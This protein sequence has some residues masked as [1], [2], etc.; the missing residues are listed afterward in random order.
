MVY[1]TTRIEKMNIKIGGI[2]KRSPVDPLMQ[3]HDDAD[4]VFYRPKGI[5]MWIGIPKVF[6]KDI[7]HSEFVMAPQ[8]PRQCPRPR[9]PCSRNDYH[10]LFS[11]I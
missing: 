2:D 7:G 10:A 5:R 9:S 1:G 8:D 6:F 4:P 11:L 3:I